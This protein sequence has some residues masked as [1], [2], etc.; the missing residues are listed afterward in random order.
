MEEQV[1]LL[2]SS[3]HKT[4][5]YWHATDIEDEGGRREEEEKKEE[6]EEGT[7]GWSDH[8]EFLLFSPYY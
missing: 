6:E 8:R 2:Y 3:I 1:S 5:Y 4:G 7:E